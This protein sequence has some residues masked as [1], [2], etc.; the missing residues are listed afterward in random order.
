MP[1]PKIK[2]YK[3]GEQMKADDNVKIESFLDGTNR[4]I[5]KSVNLNDQGNYR[6]EAINS[7]GSMSS[8]APLTVNSMFQ[9]YFYISLCSIKIEF[10][11]FSFGNSEIGE[12]P[13]RSFDYS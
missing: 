12:R 7:I 6:C 10:I 13:R 4:L 5:I 1:L 2:W 9:N 11:Y 3:D 8:K